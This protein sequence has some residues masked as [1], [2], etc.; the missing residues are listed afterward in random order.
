VPA[1]PVAV[2]TTSASGPV[3]WEARQTFA[4]WASQVVRLFAGSADVEFEFTIGP[5]PWADG[6]GKEVVSRFS[7]ANFGDSG[8]A[9][10]SDA[11]GRDSL[12]R[13]RDHRASFNYT[14]F[15]PVAGNFVPVNLFTALAS[16]GA[17]LQL[18]VVT[19]R[20]QAGSSMADGSL[21]L[22]VHRRL[23]ADDSRGVGEPHNETGL[24]GLGLIVRGVHTLRVD[25]AA[26]AGRE[27]RRLA[28]KSLFKPLARVARNAAGSAAAWLAAGHAAS[29]AGLAAPLPPNVHLTTVHSLGPGRLLLRL[30]HMFAAGE[31]AALSAPATVD[32]ATL[33]A[34]FRVK[35][36]TEMMLGGAA[37]LTA[38]PVTTYT[39]RG[40]G[41]VTLP[42]IPPP[43]AGPGLTITLSAMQ[44]RTFECEI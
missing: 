5:I 31:D 15:E 41:N 7:S 2:D 20:T 16:P 9:W 14:V 37:P 36:A 6:L 23:L 25:R 30:A 21:E 18:S 40:G 12:P 11:N 42:V 38:A 32:L 13:R 28:A 26:A 29:A 10:L 43:P 39:I 24:D 35:A 8:G 17:G 4:P 27:L 3:V 19:D 1:G 33:F 44:I 22:M 34:G